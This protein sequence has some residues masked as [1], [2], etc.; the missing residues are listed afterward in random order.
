MEDKKLTVVEHLEELRSRIIRSI[1]FIIIAS[2]FSYA[3][4]DSILR[5]MVK[6]VGKVVFISP[7]EVF[8]TNIK[9]ALLGGAYLSSPFVLYE[10]WQFISTGL[11]ERGRRYVLVFAFSSFILFILGSF[12]GYFIMAPIGMKFLLSF[13]TD[14]VSPMISVD[15]YVSFIVGFTL[16]FGLIFQ[17]PVVILFLTKIGLLTPQFLSKNRK[18]AIVIIFIVAAILTPPDVISQCLMAIP[19]L[20]L[21]EVSILLS[22]LVRR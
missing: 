19:L 11:G 13:S 2:I 16:I 17:L 6:P 9:I 10:A 20:I 7:A 21:Y 12:F 1:I 22:K 8:I 15:R 3:F 5:F 18:Y 14:F 4:T